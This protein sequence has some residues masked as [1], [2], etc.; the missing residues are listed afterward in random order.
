MYRSNTSIVEK[1]AMEM[2]LKLQ[3]AMLYYVQLMGIG[4]I[5]ANGMECSVSCGEGNQTRNRTFDGFWSNWN[6]WTACSLSC[7]GG[8]QSRN[9]TCNDP[10]PEYGGIHCSGNITE[11][12]NCNGDPCPINI[13]QSMEVG[14]HGQLGTNVVYLVEVEY[15][16]EIDHVQILIPSLVEKTCRGNATDTKSCS[17]NKC[18]IDGNWTNWS[19][20]NIC[21][22]S[23]GGG[24]M[25]RNRTCSNPEPLFGG[26]D[27]IGNNTDDNFCNTNECPV[28]GNWT[29]W[30]VW[31][32]CSQSCGRGFQSRNRTCS[33]PVPQFGGN[34]CLGN[35]TDD[36][37]CNLHN[38]PVDGNW[39]KWSEWDNCTQSCGG[40]FR[41]RV[42]TCSDPE[43]RFEGENCLGNSTEGDICN[44]HYCPV[45][46][47]WTDWSEWNSCSDTCGGGL[48]LRYRN[49]SNPEPQFGGIDCIGN[50][51]EKDSCNTH[52]CPGSST[53]VT[54]RIVKCLEDIYRRKS[55][56][57]E[58]LM[59]VVPFIVYLHIQC[60][61]KHNN[62]PKFLLNTVDGS[63][64]EWSEWDN[65]TDSCG[66]G[67]QFRNRTC[68]DPEPQFGGIDCVGNS[69]DNNVCNEHECPVD[70][71]WTEWSEWNNCTDVCGGGLKSRNRT[72]SDPEPQF[73]G[74][75]CKGNNTESTL[76]N[77]H[78]CPVDGNW[79][80]WSEWEE[81]SVSCGGGLKTRNRTCTQPEPLF[82][83]KYCIGNDTNISEC[84]DNPCPINGNWTEWSSWNKCSDTCGG[85]MKF[86]DRN[87]SNPEPQYGGELCFGNETNLETCNEEPCPIDG[88]WSGWSE[89][90]ECSVTC[91]GGIKTRN[92]TCSNPEPQFG[93][94][95]C[96]GNDTLISDC[97]ENSCPINGNWTEWSSWNE[98]SVTCGG[99][100]KVRERNCSNPIPQYGGESKSPQV[101]P[102]KTPSQSSST[103]EG[104]LKNVK[105]N[106]K[107]VTVKTAK[108]FKEINPNVRNNGS[109]RETCNKEPE[110]SLTGAQHDPY[111]FHGSQSQITEDIEMKKP[112]ESKVNPVVNS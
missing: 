88:S 93:G 109:G 73:G 82:G 8:S 69:V 100:M 14:L 107:T 52:Y 84:A 22:K 79:S 106:S 103:Q 64:A 78:Y 13:V 35:F 70:G 58:G 96:L 81:C 94:N 27:C 51:T 23:C 44:D 108:S 112:D 10:E 36:D 91:G 50:R 101:S 48:T 87:C 104:Q 42:R 71:S 80:G 86:R 40:G 5:G 39:T 19:E 54:V 3:F 38:C 46:G 105:K 85:G 65:C 63:W 102:Q 2:I 56:E 68:S 57:V 33:N 17:D 34:E 29:D 43:P 25:L 20:W 45:D 15:Y 7:G 61:I 4:P 72:C 6:E 21:S 47:N 41:S 110:I 24:L 16:I 62:H 9:R 92:R 32:T 28:D 66:G 75:D 67:L 95:Q 89:W 30:S 74:N 77:Q 11:E 76:C 37:M 12:Q 83:G 90:E 111:E 1:I 49:C 59:K 60:K 55:S 99:G 31:S 26:E 53:A 18:P 98:C 97:A